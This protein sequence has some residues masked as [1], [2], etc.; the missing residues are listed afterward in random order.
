MIYEFK[1]GLVHRRKHVAK[2]PTVKISVW[3]ILDDCPGPKIDELELASG[4][5]HNQ[6]LVLDVAVDDAAAV[7]RQHRLNHLAEKFARQIF[8]ENALLRDELEKVLKIKIELKNT[9]IKS[10]KLLSVKEKVVKF[11]TV[12][13][14]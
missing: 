9:K 13:R 6:V 14:L 12:I 2:K 1:N 4:Q 8:F 10:I 3:F 11:N 7:A 5:V